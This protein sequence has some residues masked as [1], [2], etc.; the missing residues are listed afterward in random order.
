MLC[1][2]HKELVPWWGRQYVSKSLESGTSSAVIRDCSVRVFIICVGWLRLRGQEMHGWSLKKARIQP[3]E[4]RGGK[5]SKNKGQ[6]VLPM[7]GVLRCNLRRVSPWKRNG[8]RGVGGWVGT[9]ETLNT[10]VLLMHLLKPNGLNIS[11]HL[12]KVQD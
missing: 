5:H 8:R 11:L 1:H 10:S 3:G 6:L 9:Q 12:S 2:C 4:E 7:H